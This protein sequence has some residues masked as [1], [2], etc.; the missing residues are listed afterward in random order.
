MHLVLGEG[1]LFVVE[2]ECVLFQGLLF[3]SLV[4]SSSL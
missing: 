4:V 1:T 3:S 2:E